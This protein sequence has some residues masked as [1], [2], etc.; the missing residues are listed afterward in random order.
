MLS[1]IISCKGD[2]EKGVKP[3]QRHERAWPNVRMTRDP[4]IL[5]TIVH[6]DVHL[7]LWDRERPADLG[8]LDGLDWDRIDDLDLIIDTAD[9]DRA[10]SEE[11]KGSGYPPG[12]GQR[13]LADEIGR[14]S[15]IFANLIGSDS[16]RI[17]LEVVETDA[18][19][20]F[21]ADMVDARLLTTLVGPGTQWIRI[22]DSAVVNEMRLGSV[23]I[24]KGRLLAE[25][26]SILHRSPPIAGS[27]VTRLLLAINTAVSR[28]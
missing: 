12:I 16:L 6:D 5:E 19:R 13:F 20:K 4:G 17:R 25:K 28:M 24:F 14:L 18:C 22:E 11:L 2:T 3:A 15:S 7:A 23:G 21:H 26:P 10:I 8:W 9:V 1:H 27:G